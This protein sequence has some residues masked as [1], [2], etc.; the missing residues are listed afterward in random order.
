MS[1]CKPEAIAVFLVTCLVANYLTR[2]HYVIRAC[3]L[4]VVTRL[5]GD[6]GRDRKK[7][8]ATYL[9]RPSGEVL[10]FYFS[11]S[12]IRSIAKIKSTIQALTLVK[13]IDTSA[14]FPH[15][16]YG[17]SDDS[18][19]S[20]CSHQYRKHQ[21]HA[22]S[23]NSLTIFHFSNASKQD[24]SIYMYAF[25]VIHKRSARTRFL[26]LSDE[27]RSCAQVSDITS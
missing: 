27:N 8:L 6:D 5:G 12:Q 22:P 18:R 17:P 13:I 4:K 7:D 21:I 15:L 9:T 2:M 3:G 19:S 14:V 25:E 24:S 16:E 20:R 1:Q 26:K 23:Y 10:S 11:H